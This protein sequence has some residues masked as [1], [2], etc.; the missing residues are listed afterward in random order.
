MSTPFRLKRSAVSGKRPG[1]SDL[2]RGEL[3]LNF[4]DG[5]L[6]AERDTGGVG[7]GTTISLLTPWT[8]NFGGDSIYY[9]NSVGVGTEAPRAKFDVDGSLNVS[10]I[11]TF[12][13]D[14]NLIGSTAGITSAYWDSSANT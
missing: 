4:Y 11:S 12:G 10:G 2:Q 8:E 7:I 3:A 5:Y 13:N 6:F 14:V 1:L 9:S